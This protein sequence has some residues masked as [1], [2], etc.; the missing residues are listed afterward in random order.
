MIQLFSFKISLTFLDNIR[1]L[2]T[3]IIKYTTFYKEKGVW[4][5]LFIK[6]DM[7]DLI[8]SSLELLLASSF[9]AS[10]VSSSIA[11]THND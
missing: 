9:L 1:F 4:M 5:Y 8:R 10:S 7:I 11:P 2:L 6:L 3:L